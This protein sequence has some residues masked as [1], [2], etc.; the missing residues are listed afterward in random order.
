MFI[1]IANII[2]SPFPIY[3]STQFLYQLW[4]L[5]PSD[6]TIF[7]PTTNS[8]YAGIIVIMNSVDIKKPFCF[9]FALKKMGTFFS[10]DFVKVSSSYTLMHWQRNEMPI[11]CIVSKAYSQFEFE[12]QLGPNFSHLSE[13]V[14]LALSRVETTKWIFRANISKL[15]YP[16]I[17]RK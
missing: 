1:K 17:S 15:K 2:K 6:L 11:L 12:F 8:N 7:W 14:L 13:K 4:P 3:C 5:S 10:C 9:E 16:F